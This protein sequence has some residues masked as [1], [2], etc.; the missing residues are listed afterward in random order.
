MRECKACGKKIPKI[1]L[2]A[3]PNTQFCVKCVD[4]N[5]SGKVAVPIYS[6]DGVDVALI[7]KESASIIKNLSRNDVK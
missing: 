7:D 5:D 2:E 3:V 4:E 6:I 1:R